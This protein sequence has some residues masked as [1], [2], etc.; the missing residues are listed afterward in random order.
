MKLFFSCA[1]EALAIRSDGLGRAGFALAFRKK[2]GSRSSR[3][4]AAVF[5]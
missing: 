5:I 1:L 4:F 2:C 3:E